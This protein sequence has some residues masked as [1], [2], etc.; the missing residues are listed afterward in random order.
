[1]ES[2]PEFFLSWQELGLA[3]E[4]I[5]NTTNIREIQIKTILHLWEL[6]STKSLQVTNVGDDVEKRKTLYTVD[7]NITY[8][9]YSYV[10]HNW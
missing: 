5:I 3:H 4:K 7:R 6:L 2:S 8:M 1:M 9:F 10:E